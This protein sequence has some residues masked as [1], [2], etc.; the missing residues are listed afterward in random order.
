MISSLSDENQHAL[1]TL[2]KFIG[3]TVFGVWGLLV[4]GWG[5]A[6]IGWAPSIA[7]GTFIV[8]FSLI[9]LACAWAFLFYI[10]TEVWSEL[11]RGYH[12]EKGQGDTKEYKYRLDMSKISPEMK[13]YHILRYGQ[14]SIDNGLDITQEYYDDLPDDVKELF[15]EI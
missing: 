14:E 4:I 6:T 9:G 1:K 8:V 12:V 11:K 13:L 15:N 2:A 5:L 10:P 7:H 3:K